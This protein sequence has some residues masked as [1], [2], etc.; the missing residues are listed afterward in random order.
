MGSINHLDS[1]SSSTNRVGSIEVS[2][3]NRNWG[4]DSESLEGNLSA[5]KNG[6]IV[7][8]V[9]S[10]VLQVHSLISS[11]VRVGCRVIGVHLTV[12]GNTS[13]WQV[14]KEVGISSDSGDWLADNG[15]R[16]FLDVLL[17]ALG[18]NS[19]VVLLSDVVDEGVRTSSSCGRGAECSDIGGEDVSREVDG[20][21]VWVWG[22]DGVSVDGVE[23]GVD[24]ESRSAGAVGVLGER[25]TSKTIDGVSGIRESH[26]VLV[27]SKSSTCDFGGISL[28][29]GIGSVEASDSSE[30]VAG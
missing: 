6:I 20:S 19:E 29:D 2:E 18:R 12:L 25:K 21:W 9:S 13:V 23:G 14:S 16:P 30:D 10:I 4:T 11:G 15:N 3:L 22:V 24:P 7:T 17:D 8:I 28:L 5:E 27:V 1:G 26:V